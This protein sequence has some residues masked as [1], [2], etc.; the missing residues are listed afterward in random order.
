MKSL[1]LLAGLA[2]GVLDVLAP[3]RLN[4]LGAT[5]VIIGV[6]FL[7]A[8][9]IEAALSPLV[10]RLSDRRGALTP[11]RLSLSVAVAVSLLAP[12]LAPAPLLVV[13]LIVGLPSFGTLY[14]PSATLL[15][16]GA[17][18]LKLN[19]GL[20]FGLANLAWATGQAIGSAASGALAQVTS[21]LLPYTLL[22]SVCLVTLV[23]LRPRTRAIR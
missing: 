15:S 23:I 7:A 8:S 6:T 12:L 5:A 11:V 21:D 22:A 19:Q 4:S 13:L 2:L 9:A 14:A 10:G 18:R 3:L 1:R 20:A 16:T 17:D